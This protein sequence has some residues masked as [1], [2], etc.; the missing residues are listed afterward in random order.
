MNA[1]SQNTLPI[2]AYLA[3]G[4]N[5]GD[6]EL[7]LATALKCIDSFDAVELLQVSTNIETRPLAGLDQ[8][9]YLNCVSSIKTTLAPQE[10]L[11]CIQSIESALGRKANSHGQSRPI[12]IDILLYGNRTL[13]SENLTIPHSQ[14]HLRSFVLKPLTQIA[15]EVIHPVLNENASEL[16]LRLNGSDY[17]LGNFNSQLITIAGVIGVGKTTLARG[18]SKELGAGLIEEDYDKN[19]FLA[20]VYAGQ[21]EL[22]L[23]SD[24]YFLRNAVSQ[25][26]KS[27]LM[28]KKIS[29]ADY[30]FEKTLI[31][32]DYWLD[33]SSF[34]KYCKNYEEVFEQIQ[35]PSVVIYLEDEIDNCLLRIKKRARSFE[36]DMNRALLE[37]LK[38]EYDKLF[39]NWNSCPVLR[40]NAGDCDFRSIDQVK[41]LAAQVRSYL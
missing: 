12:D 16:C 14:M 26:S 19:P 21:S 20:K 31:Y 18:L 11:N 3:L 28:A 24:L 30:V 36:V 15:P 32:A 25:L 10:L 13:F 8:P 40:V 6:R 27:S 1:N 17:F 4:S 34:E 2:T 9:D 5:L 41:L 7:N 33:F 29:V 23:D 37:T 35:T 38:I 22:A 39:E